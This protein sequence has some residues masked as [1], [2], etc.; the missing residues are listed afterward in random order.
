[1]GVVDNTLVIVGGVEAS[2]KKSG[3]VTVWDATGRQWREGLYPNLAH[4]RAN[5]CVVTY[6]NWL[7]VV[8][9]TGTGTVEK[10]DMDTSKSWTPCPPIPERCS[11]ISCVAIDHTLYAAVTIVSNAS[12]SSS[13]SLQD[14][15]SG[16]GG[17]NVRGLF[18]V[19][20][21][22]LVRIKPKDTTVWSKMAA[23][24]TSS[25][26]LCTLTQRS[27]LAVGGEID[28]S[29]S[30]PQL[31]PVLSLELRKGA[32]IKWERVGSLPCERMCCT[33]LGVGMAEQGSCCRVVVL[34]GT[35]T[36]AQEGLQ[37]VDVGTLKG[38]R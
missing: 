36:G 7:L 18:S 27:L 28:A 1:M 19:F 3:K 29:S 2:H 21:P 37:R 8:G 10:L 26:S 31:S 13:V 5:P 6:E 32:G 22:L 23:I 14:Q 16:G 9:G 11:H 17:S 20:L 15:G 25:S 35:Q 33:C 30:L 38:Q 12:F 34:G 4:A 24:P